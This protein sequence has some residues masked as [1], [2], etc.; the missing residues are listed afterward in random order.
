MVAG[1]STTHRAL[2]EAWNEASR[3]RSG[4]IVASLRHLC[5]GEF[6]EIIVSDHGKHKSVLKFNMRVML[7]S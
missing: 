5:S 4:S 2:N 1:P 3:L 7:R 6:R